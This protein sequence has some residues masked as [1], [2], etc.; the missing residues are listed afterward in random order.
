MTS[1][2]DQAVDVLGRAR[3]FGAWVQDILDATEV[4]VRDRQLELGEL[5]DLGY[6]FRQIESLADELRKA[7]KTRGNLIGHTVA[8]A[9]AERGD[10]GPFR[11]TI[12]DAVPSGARVFL[13]PPSGSPREIDAMVALGV[14]REVAQLGVLTLEAR[15]LDDHCQDRAQAGQVPLPGVALS[16]PRIGATF[17]PL[18][19]ARNA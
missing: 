11:G 19:K 17:R 16:H 9:A 6:V 3:D 5:A 13:P 7:A 4:P 14:P 1:L 15:R 10:L 12:A 8:V 2:V 18:T